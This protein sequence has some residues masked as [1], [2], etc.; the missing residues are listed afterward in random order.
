M[1]DI[2]F[3]NIIAHVLDIEEG[4]SLMDLEVDKS[5]K[6]CELLKKHIEKSQKSDRHKLA[7]FSDENN[8]IRECCINIFE[9]NNFIDNSRKIAK[10]LFN[11]MPKTASSANLIICTY[12]IDDK[13]EISFLK[14]DY[15]ENFI[16]NK[17][18]VDGKLKLKID[19]KNG[20]PNKNDKLQKCVFI[21]KSALDNNEDPKSNPLVILDK[22]SKLEDV[23]DYFSRG[24]L[25]CELINSDK[26]NTRIFIEECIDT[27][28]K[29]YVNNIKKL[30]ECN[31]RMWSV[32]NENKGKNICIHDIARDII[33]DEDKREEFITILSSN[34]KID[35]N[36][37]IDKNYLDARNKKIE[38]KTNNNIKITCNLE[39]WEDDSIIDKEYL[40][41]TR[42]NIII[43]G[44]EII[45]NK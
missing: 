39:Q 31:S 21:S 17:I 45:H 3:K 42:A 33:K 26:E 8:M 37:N 30:D 6:L 4:L 10:K 24:F 28:N 2:E 29:I 9:N 35:F 13:E 36:F 32:L 27:L 19:I 41:D 38:I 25:E 20:L 23:S 44:V 34:R 18:E 14:M 1:S 5:T 7:K 43:K 40:S 15:S 22:Q 16:T 11:S 12:I